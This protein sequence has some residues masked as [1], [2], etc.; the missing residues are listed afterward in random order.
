MRIITVITLLYLS[1]TFV[2]TF[3]GT[4]VIKYQDQ[5]EGKIYFSGEALRSFSYVTIPLWV[6]TIAVAY[7]LNIKEAKKR[8]ESALQMVSKYPALCTPSSLISTASR[9]IKE[10]GT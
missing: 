2:C 1:P 4:D 3:F 10:K 8:G 5:G 7:F 9:D 6:V